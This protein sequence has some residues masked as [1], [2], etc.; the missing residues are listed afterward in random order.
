MESFF[1]Y[2]LNNIKHV[3]IKLLQNSR[4]KSQ[5]FYRWRATVYI[6]IT[7]ILYIGTQ[8]DIILLCIIKSTH[9]GPSYKTGNPFIRYTYTVRIRAIIYYFIHTN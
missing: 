8:L 3:K 9:I 7:C 1:S 6:Q 5:C 2:Y 4:A